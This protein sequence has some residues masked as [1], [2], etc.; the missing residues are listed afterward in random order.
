MDLRLRMTIA[1]GPTATAR[2][3]RAATRLATWQYACFALSRD[4]DSQRPS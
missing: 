1:D 4:E 2:E 3:A